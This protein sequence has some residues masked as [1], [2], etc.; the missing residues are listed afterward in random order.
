MIF[1]GRT[2]GIRDLRNEFCLAWVLTLQ[3]CPFQKFRLN[4]FHTKKIRQFAEQVTFRYAYSY[5]K[6][7]LLDKV[8]SVWYQRN[9]IRG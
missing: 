8:A 6:I 5:Y 3:M 7:G 1:P 4:L 9:E 2:V